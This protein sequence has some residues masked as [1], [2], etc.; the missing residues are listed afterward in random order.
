MRLIILYSFNA[1][2]MNLKSSRHTWTNYQPTMCPAT[3]GGHATP[4]ERKESKKENEGTCRLT[5]TLQFSI[6]IATISTTI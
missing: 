4:E 5:L 3:A 1:E 6:S 2:G